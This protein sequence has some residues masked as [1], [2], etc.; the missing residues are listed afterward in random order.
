MTGAVH[1]RPVTTFTA[2]LGPAGDTVDAP[3]VLR[4]PTGRRLLVQRGDTEV[5]VVDLDAEG[6]PHT[7]S[8]D[9]GALHLWALHAPRS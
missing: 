5:A 9:G 8:P 6:A 7:T 2:P 4:W 1:V 3:S